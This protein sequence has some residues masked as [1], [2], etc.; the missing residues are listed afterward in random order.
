MKNSLSFYEILN[1]P[2]PKFKDY[3]RIHEKKDI[4]YGFLNEKKFSRNE[5][6]T[7][8][9]TYISHINKYSYLFKNLPF[10]NQI[11]LCNGITFNKLDSNS[12][13]DLL[14][15]CKPNRLL[16]TRFYFSVFFTIL[17]LRWFNNKQALKFDLGFFV[18]A[19]SL[20]FF[21][22][23]IKP[24]DIYFFYWIAHL[25]PLYSENI[26]NSNIVFEDNKWLSEFLLNWKPLQSIFLGV[27]LISGKGI[28]KKTIE[29]LNYGIIGNIFESILKL[30]W[31][32][33]ILI[34]AKKI[35]SR[36]DIYITENTLRFYRNSFRKKINTKYKNYRQ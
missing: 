36:D 16:L 6:D 14:V 22:Q 15:V 8:L 12:D 26:N 24:H 4:D 2:E 18:T 31:L 17:G 34:R 1:Y 3:F 20:N 13:I 21:Q 19:D 23:C 25:V 10:V 28:V 29:F 35:G 9:N 11:Y 32:P 30:V 5:K 33:I 27:K 7:L